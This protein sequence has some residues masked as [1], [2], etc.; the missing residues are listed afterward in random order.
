[1]VDFAEIMR[2][3]NADSNNGGGSGSTS[4]GGGS[5]GGAKPTASSSNPNSDALK[6]RVL[7]KEE[8]RGEQISEEKKNELTPRE[9]AEAEAQ[10]T[11]IALNLNPV[12]TANLIYDVGNRAALGA[13]IDQNMV[14]ESVQR[15][16]GIPAFMLEAMRA[17]EP[18]RGA[19]ICSPQS[20]ALGTDSNFSDELRQV[21][22]RQQSV[23]GLAVT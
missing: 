19:G 15:N 1:V 22:E 12:Q 21:G 5:G 8:A 2:K 17:G 3:A 10:R 6:D 13:T 18:A 7:F 16:A 23:A 9:A 4:G 20:F 11:A 14:N